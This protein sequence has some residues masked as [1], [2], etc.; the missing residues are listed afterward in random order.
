VTLG[1][2]AMV[3]EGRRAHLGLHRLDLPELLFAVKET[4]TGGR[5]AS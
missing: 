4:S 3:P 2:V 1:A 5:R